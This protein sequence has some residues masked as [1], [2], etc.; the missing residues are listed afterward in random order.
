MQATLAFGVDLVPGAILPEDDALQRMRIAFDRLNT[1]IIAV[2]VATA[3]LDQGA[4]TRPPTGYRPRTSLEHSRWQY[5]SPQAVE[6]YMVD[7]TGY[8]G[9]KGVAETRDIL[10][11]TLVSICGKSA[12]VLTSEEADSFE[13]AAGDALRRL[14]ELVLQAALLVSGPPPPAS[15]PPAARA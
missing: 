10:S 6:I 1:A 9:W 12:K 3:T 11:R 2:L 4:S 15:D 7:L 5:P 13:S 14:S 8:A